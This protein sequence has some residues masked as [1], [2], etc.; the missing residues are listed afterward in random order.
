MD[1][2]HGCM[3]SG[4]EDS[5]VSPDATGEKHGRGG[6]VRGR[7]ALGEPVEHEQGF[8]KEAPTEREA[9]VWG[10]SRVHNGANCAKCQNLA[11]ERGQREVEREGERGA[12]ALSNERHKS[13]WE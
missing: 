11:Q 2:V 7:E 5:Q 13:F 12:R 4:G 8:G 3:H 6:R 1:K 10:H 9:G